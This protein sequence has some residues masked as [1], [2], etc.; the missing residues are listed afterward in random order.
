MFMFIHSSEQLHV[1]HE[2]C[3]ILVFP[4]LHTARFIPRPVVT[5]TNTLAT[6]NQIV[7]IVTVVPRRGTISPGIA[8]SL[9]TVSYTAI[10]RVMKVWTALVV[11]LRGLRG[12]RR[13]ICS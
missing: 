11:T 12:D 7:A 5:I 6:S 4:A 8:I 1:P 9:S 2:V 3:S 10:V 13:R